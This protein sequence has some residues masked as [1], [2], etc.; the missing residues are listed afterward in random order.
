DLLYSLQETDTLIYT[1]MFKT[2]ERQLMRPAFDRFPRGGGRGGVFGGGMGGRFPRSGSPRFPRDDDRS[3]RRRERAE[4]E[5]AEAQEF[6]QKLSDTTAGRFY[7]SKDG[8]LKKTFAMIVE[9]L[10]YQYRLGFYPP[11]QA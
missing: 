6:L 8:K 11:E 9:E 2:D 7:S 1:I 10:R 3:D 4:R 5:N